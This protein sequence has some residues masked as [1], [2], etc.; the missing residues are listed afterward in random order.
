MG[1][2]TLTSRNR[3]AAAM[4]AVLPFAL[5][6]APLAAQSYA[7]VQAVPGPASGEL[8]SALQRLAR[9]PADF[10]ALV[11]AGRASLALDDVDAAIGFFGRAETVR[12]GDPRVKAGLASANL[13]SGRPIEAIDL[14]AQAQASGAQVEAIAADRGLAYDLVG[15]N[16]SAQGQYKLALSRNRDDEI[17]R[18]MALSQAIAGDTR[19]FEATLLPL[20]QRRDLAAYRAR[21]FG[22]AIL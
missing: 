13:K 11:A 7:V 19:A 14:F 21:A 6:S 4:L 22:L 3:H 18:R 5:V 16:A 17:V 9:N 8:S 1:E 15:D 20:L 12:A 2:R 10:E